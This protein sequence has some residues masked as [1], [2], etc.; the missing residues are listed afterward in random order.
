MLTSVKLKCYGI[1]TIIISSYTGLDFWQIKFGEIMKIHQICQTLVPPTFRHLRYV[2]FNQ[3]AENIN[4]E[5]L[6]YEHNP[7]YIYQQSIY[8][9]TN[10]GV[11]QLPFSTGILCYCS[12]QLQKCDINQ[13]HPIF[14]GQTLAINL[15][16][17][18]R[19]DLSIKTS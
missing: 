3:E 18:H 16:I 9:Q 17:N 19:V 2:F 10:F 5:M 1:D 15:C 13:L 4:C 8:F 14:P 11:E 7:L 12:G 6:F